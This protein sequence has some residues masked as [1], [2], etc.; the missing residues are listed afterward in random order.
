MTHSVRNRELNGPHMSTPQDPIDLLKALV[1]PEL[2][3][4]ELANRLGVGRSTISQWRSRGLP[5]ALECL[6]PFVNSSSWLGRMLADDGRLTSLVSWLVARWDG[7]TEFERG[8]LHGRFL[9]AFPEARRTQWAHS[10]RSDTVPNLANPI[11]LKSRKVF[12][13]EPP[14]MPGAEAIRIFLGGLEGGVEGYLLFDQKWMRFHGFDAS[15]CIL[16]RV[17][18]D[19]MAPTIFGE[20]LALV[21]RGQRQRRAWGVY[22]STYS[23]GS[24]YIVSRAMR[25]GSSWYHDFDDPD[26]SRRPWLPE[27][28]VI[29]EVVWTE[30]GPLVGVSRAEGQRV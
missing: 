15:Q 14:D 12:A 4:S 17:P 6:L 25:D 29:G 3:D 18:G 10:V 27:E 21:D 11:A 13:G 7:A 22:A 30:S 5:R 9:A 20:S 26:Q 23:S 16:L 2:S 28:E 24:G 1:G 8:E 19:E